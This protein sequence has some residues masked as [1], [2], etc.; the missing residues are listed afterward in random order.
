MTTQLSIFDAEPPA[1]DDLTPPKIERALPL[2]HQ[3]RVPVGLEPCE[4]TADQLHKAITKIYEETRDRNSF[5]TFCEV[6]WATLRRFEG[7]EEEY[8]ELISEWPRPA[9]MAAKEG[10]Q[11]LI[12][13]FWHD[14]E[15]YDV[16]GDAYMRIRSKWAG[17]VLGQYFTPW[18]MCRMMAR[19]IMSGIDVD[20][21][22]NGPPI[23]IQDP[24]C[25]S[26]SMLLAAKAAMVE[27]YGGEFDHWREPAN[28]LKVYGQDIDRVCWLM[29]SIQMRMSH[30]PWMTS[31]MMATHLEA[32]GGKS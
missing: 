24:A 4:R 15:L 25:G 5:R 20:R 18:P 10:I 22:R 16:M 14:G 29:C 7:A 1:G 27:L 17:D 6:V 28:S 30:A 26:G 23:T 9:L 8:M 12:Q 32:M 2:P 3:V 31:F 19:Q 13:H 21:I 11:I